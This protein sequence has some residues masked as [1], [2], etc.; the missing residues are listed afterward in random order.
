MTDT[1]I[2]QT[3]LNGCD[4]FGLMQRLEVLF[5]KFTKYDARLFSFHPCADVD[6][7]VR[8]P[9]Q[10]LLVEREASMQPV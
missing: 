10:G 3:R 2:H 1:H 9:C 4:L 5:H 6:V 8:I 7:V